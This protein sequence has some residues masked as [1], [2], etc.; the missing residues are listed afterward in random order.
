MADTIAQ[1]EAKI[2]ALRDAKQALLLAPTK[3]TV[4]D[5]TYDNTGRIKMLNAEIRQLQDEL[6]AARGACTVPRRVV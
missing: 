2:A 6:R 4:G 3:G 5:D 1:L